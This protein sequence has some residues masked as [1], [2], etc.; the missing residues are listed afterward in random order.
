MN[1]QL[2]KVIHFIGIA[3]SGMSPLAEIAIFQGYQVS[4]SDLYESNVTKRLQELGAKLFFGQSPDHLPSNATVV[5]SSAI[6]DS[7][8]ELQAAKNQN[9][10]VIH[11]S[12]LLVILSGSKKLITVAG[13]HGKTTTTAMIAHMLHE[14][15]LAPTAAV[16]GIVEGFESSALTGDGEYFL[17]EADESDGTFLKF[18]P[19]ISILTNADVDHLDFWENEE[20][21]HKAFSNYLKNT[22]EEG[23][24]IVCWDNR[25]SYLIGCE[26]K[27]INRLSYGFRIGSD[28]RAINWEGNGHNTI[29]SA[30]IDKTPVTVNIPAIGQHNVLNALCAL[31]VAQ[32]LELNIQEAAESLSRFSGVKR[33]MSL[34][35]SSQKFK[36]YDDYAHNPG[37]ISACIKGLKNAWPSQSLVVLFQP[38]RFSR[39]RTLY[40]EIISSFKEADSVFIFPVYHAGEPIDKN[41][42]GPQLASDIAH[43]SKTTATYSEE[44]DQFLEKSL[45]IINKPTT[46]LTVGAGDIWKLTEKIGSILNGEKELEKKHLG[47]TKT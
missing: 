18:N 41:F 24:I 32:A 16:G 27:S 26:S 46:I 31:T 29:F 9:L 30:M 7:N 15:G 44:F 40:N 25:G 34:I 5:I 42:S 6:D 17:A 36:V 2:E 11:R 28:I 35:F 1:P 33:R 10:R 14:L 20:E 23:N 12:D 22:D 3:G 21:L 8:V 13:S 4:G 47:G 37:K 39:L 19:Y 38:H 45:R 43:H